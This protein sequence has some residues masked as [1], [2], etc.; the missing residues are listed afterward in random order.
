MVSIRFSMVFDVDAGALLEALMDPQDLFAEHPKIEAFRAYREL[1]VYEVRIRLRRFL[2][3]LVEAI[4]FT[5]RRTDNIVRYESL[6][7]GKLRASFRIWRELETT[8][9]EAVIEYE[10]GLRGS[11]VDETIKSIFQKVLE[12]AE[13]KAREAGIAVGKREERATSPGVEVETIKTREIEKTEKEIGITCIT[14]L[15]YEH[16]LRICTYLAKKVENP[17]KPL[18]GGDKYIRAQT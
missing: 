2:A 5:V 11:A 9:V 4:L 16:E 13:R 7:P 18:C 12:R 6:E 15:L 3:T 17:E 10:L 14:C 1:G 8:M